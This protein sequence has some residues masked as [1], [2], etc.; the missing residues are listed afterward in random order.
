MLKSLI[1]S[2]SFFVASLLC[3]PVQ[4]AR[5]TTKAFEFEVEGVAGVWMPSAMA[6]LALA[7]AEEL[8]VQKVVIAEQSA[9]IAIKDERL[10]IK[11]QRILQVK[12][13]LQL[14]I[15]A[16]ERTKAVVEAAV[17]GQRE[18][19]EALDAWYRSPGFLLSLGGLGVIVIEV[20]AILLFTQVS[21]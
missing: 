17:R 15:Q 8:A 10:G 21:K 20:G 7:S 18:A 5:D 16:E 9:L 13:A 12:E 4:A 3:S 6:K 14:S 2:T 1:V 19:E 11:D